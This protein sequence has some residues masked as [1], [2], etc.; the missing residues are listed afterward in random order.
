MYYLLTPILVWG[1]AS[2]SQQFVVVAE[3]ILRM[4]LGRRATKNRLKS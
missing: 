1:M 2:S 3:K 4:L